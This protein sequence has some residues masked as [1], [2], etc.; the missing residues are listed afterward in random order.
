[1]PPKFIKRSLSS[2]TE[3]DPHALLLKIAETLGVGKLDDILP[4]I[5]RLQA[6][7][8]EDVIVIDDDDEK[9]EEVIDEVD[10][11]AEHITPECD[12]RH[13]LWKD[14]TSSLSHLKPGKHD[15][16][17]FKAL[18]HPRYTHQ[19]GQS[20][21]IQLGHTM[22][23]VVIRIMSLSS[24][25]KRVHIPNKRG[26]REK[27]H[28]FVNTVSGEVIVLEQKN[29]LDLDTEKCKSTSSKLTT[30]GD[31]IL[32]D[33]N[34]REILGRDPTS[35]RSFI[36]ASRYLR[37]TDIPVIISRKYPDVPILGM[38]DLFEYAGVPGEALFG[39]E[40]AYREFINDFLLP[41]ILA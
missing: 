33:S 9:E 30:L 14:I 35:I 28:V 38:D 24:I 2:A 7:C 25:W 31:E 21:N 20:T 41:N 19:I 32:E 23:D 22:Q 12:T 5:E 4:T 16:A 3:M 34:I 27:D 8:S 11:K 26:K 37:K 40:E 13:S 1:M 36:L 18:I 10:A 29:N 6:K 17:S 15:D 39:T